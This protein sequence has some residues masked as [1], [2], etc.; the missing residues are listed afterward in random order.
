MIRGCAG[1]IPVNV[2]LQGWKMIAKECPRC[3]GRLVELEGEYVLLPGADV[4]AFGSKTEIMITPKRTL[5]VRV[6]RCEN[7]ACTLVELHAS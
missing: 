4:P 5:R 2:G 3:G 7:P 1:S 6:Y